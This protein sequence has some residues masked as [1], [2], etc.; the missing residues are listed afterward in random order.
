MT[1]ICTA[2]EKDGMQSILMEATIC[3]FAAYHCA[4]HGSCADCPQ[5]DWVITD[6]D[7]EDD[8]GE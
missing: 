3:P 2:Q 8:G 5:I 1:I 4:A 7:D 6:T